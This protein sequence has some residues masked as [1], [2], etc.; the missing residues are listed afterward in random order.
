MNGYF[1]GD[2]V[3]EAGMA[4][5]VVEL[6]LDVETGTEGRGERAGNGGEE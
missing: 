3:D 1:A 5:D 2:S 4:V 6:D